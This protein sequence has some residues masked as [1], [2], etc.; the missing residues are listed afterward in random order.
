MGTYNLLDQ[1]GKEVLFL[2][3]YKCLTERVDVKDAIPFP[4]AEWRACRLDE[5]EWLDPGV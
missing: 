5:D 2:I 1:V 4:F 3:S